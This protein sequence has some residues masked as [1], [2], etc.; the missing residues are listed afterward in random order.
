[1]VER[2][3]L[4]SLRD[5][6]STTAVEPKDR[7]IAIADLNHNPCPRRGDTLSPNCLADG[8]E[9]RDVPRN[10]RTGQFLASVVWED[11]IGIVEVKIEPCHYER[12][13]AAFLSGSISACVENGFVR[14]EMHPVSSAALG[15]CR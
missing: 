14:N 4:Y 5:V 8:L 9:E 3:R 6:V 2:R 11:V 13:A 7:S 12:S 10:D 15:S 1:M